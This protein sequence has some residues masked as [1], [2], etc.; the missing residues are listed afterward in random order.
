MSAFITA[1]NTAAE[2][3]RHH[4]LAQVKA[5][6]AIGHARECGK[7]LLQ[8][9]QTL[10][11]GEWL[12]WLR[13]NTTISLRT[14]QRYLAVAEGRPAKK[15]IRQVAH[16]PDPL[17]LAASFAGGTEIPLGSIGLVEWK[18]PTG[19]PNVLEM[20]PVLWPDGETRGLHYAH[21]E[22]DD[23][24]NGTYDSGANLTTTRRP[25][26]EGMCSVQQIAERVGA[27]MEG[28]QVYEG[29]PALWQPW[30]QLDLPYLKG[31]LL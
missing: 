26:R 19:R 12:P 14:A 20:H 31:S 1:A 2:I 13:A 29:K 25:M 24:P 8:V 17:S 3:N 7:L 22:A 23:T 9:R 18:D 5:N 11:H 4:A 6:E 27:P 28:L 10:M 30:R 15:Q 21:L 16:L